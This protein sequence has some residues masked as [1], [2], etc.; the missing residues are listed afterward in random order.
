MRLKAPFMFPFWITYCLWRYCLQLINRPYGGGFIPNYQQQQKILAL[1][2]PKLPN[3]K[4]PWFLDFA[5]NV[6][7]LD[8]RNLFCVTASGHSIRKTLFYNLFSYLQVHTTRAGMLSALLC[9]THGALSLDGGMI[10]KNGLFA[11]GSK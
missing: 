9:T 10:K 1:L 2:K 4:S 5:V 7:N 6:V 8:E 3:K 11:L